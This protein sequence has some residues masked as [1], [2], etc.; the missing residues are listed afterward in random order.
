MV[1]YNNNFEGGI[2]GTTLTTANMGGASGDAPSTVVLGANSNW[3]FQAS[4][5]AHGSF[6]GALT[7]TA[8]N[9]TAYAEYNVAPADRYTWRAYFRLSALPTS[10]TL[11]ARWRD[12]A[13]TPGTIANIAISDSNRIQFENNVSSPVAALQGGVTLV[14]GT[15]YR[16]EVGVNS[17]TALA[18]WS[19]FAGDSTTP[20]E[21]KAAAAFASTGLQVGKFR[22]GRVSGTAFIG[23]IDFDDLQLQDLV[24]G[25]PGPISNAST[26]VR[27]SSIL[28]NPGV[29]T[30]VG[31]AANLPTALADELDTTFVQSPANPSATVVTFGL[32]ELSAGTPTITVRHNVDAASPVISTTYSLMQGATVISTR[33][34]TPMPTVITDYS[35]TATSGETALITDRTQLSLRISTTV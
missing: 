11:I 18:E 16:L 25:L 34:V 22:F 10:R 6:G 23:T 20:L 3:S 17:V 19:L 8:I 27:P 29:F 4:A 15:L 7:T 5:A 30:N 21:T 14:A 35:W 24:T 1:A 26:T 12:T 32:P 33:T 28:S 2:E 9:V 31:G 13:A